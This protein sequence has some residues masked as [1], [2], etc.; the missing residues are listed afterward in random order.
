LLQLQLQF[1][2]QFHVIIDGDQL[3]HRFEGVVF[4]VSVLSVQHNQ[5]TGGKFCTFTQTLQLAL[6]K[7]VQS[8][9]HE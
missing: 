7:A 1:H 6:G 9:A 3:E 8:V 5:F 4:K 2:G